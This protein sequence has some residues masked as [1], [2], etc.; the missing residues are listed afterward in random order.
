MSHDNIRLERGDQ[1]GDTFDA[2]FHHIRHRALQQMIDLLLLPQIG[3][4]KGSTHALLQRTEV[5]VESF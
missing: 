1:T 3:R 4:Q 2:S 5:L